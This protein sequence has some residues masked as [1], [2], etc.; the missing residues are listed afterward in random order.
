MRR[1]ILTQERIVEA[2][3]MS[4]G[5]IAVAAQKIGVNRSTLAR[6]ID[7]EP[8]LQEARAD[9]MQTNLD[10]CEASL[11]KL[12]AQT[13]RAS[14]MFFLECFGKDRGWVKS[15]RVEGKGGGPLEIVTTQLTP[16]EFDE[17]AKRIA[18]EI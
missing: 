15:L 8:E 5:V 4:A 2:L 3:R 18:Q 11:F 14:I 16:D 17:R 7:D 9:I 10:L 1:D 13:D 6:W 12:I